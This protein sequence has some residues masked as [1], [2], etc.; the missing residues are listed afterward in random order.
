V[1]GKEERYRE[2]SE[3]IKFGSHYYNKSIYFSWLESYMLTKQGNLERSLKLL[4][5]ALTSCEKQGLPFRS[6]RLLFEKGWVLFLCQEWEEALACLLSASDH[7]PP[8]PFTQLLLGACSCM[9]GQLDQAE[10]WFQGLGDLNLEKST[11]E[12][13]IGRRAKRYLNRRWFQ[14]F[15]YEIIYVTD[16][17]NGM[18]RD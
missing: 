8:S 4:E 11:I 10:E 6:P 2:A 12:R 1:P 16:Y 7:S 5:R 9:T 18:K 13:W 14:L 15:P 3:L 17:L